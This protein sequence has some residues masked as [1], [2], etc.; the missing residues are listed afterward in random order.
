MTPFHRKP[1]SR[2]QALFALSPDAPILREQNKHE[3]ICRRLAVLITNVFA[4]NFHHHDGRARRSMPVCV[5]VCSLSVCI[6]MGSRY[7]PFFLNECSN[8]SWVWSEMRVHLCTFSQS[9][10][11]DSPPQRNALNPAKIQTLLCNTG[12]V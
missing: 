3:H 5:F 12:A 9:Q 8:L 2:L 11:I 1:E 7:Y 10:R 6:H 4:D